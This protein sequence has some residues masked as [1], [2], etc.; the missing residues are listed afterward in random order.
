MSDFL[1]LPIRIL[2]KELL[3]LEYLVNTGP[4]IARLSAFG[5]ANLFADIPTSVNTP[6]ENFSTEVA[7][8]FG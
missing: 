6:Y 7:I 2:L 5:K 4:R 3:C 8:A 1:G